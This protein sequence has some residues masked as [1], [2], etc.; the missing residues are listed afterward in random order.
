MG[1]HPRRSPCRHSWVQQPHLALLRWLPSQ[2][3]PLSGTRA[4]V[5]TPGNF[6][7]HSWQDSSTFPTGSQ[8][9]LTGGHVPAQHFGGQE[10]IFTLASGW[11]LAS[12][13][14]RTEDRADPEGIVVGSTSPRKGKQNT[15]MPFCRETVLVPVQ[16]TE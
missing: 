8:T 6:E 14:R 15:R 9:A 3:A 16:H 7:S 11:E 4:G 1:D 10:C 2:G 5:G 12:R 13:T